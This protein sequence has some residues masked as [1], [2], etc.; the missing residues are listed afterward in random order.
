KGTGV[1]LTG[2][3]RYKG[4]NKV[5]IEAE[6]DKGDA[7]IAALTYQGGVPKGIR[8]IRFPEPKVAPEKEAGRPAIVLTEDKTIQKAHKVTD[9]FGLYQLAGGREA[10]SAT[11]MF[12]KT[13]KVDLGK[14]KKIAR[15]E[16]SD[17]R[18]VVWQVEQKGGDD[19][20]LTLLTAA[21]L[22]G[23]PAKLVGLVGKVPAGFVLF[24]PVSI[25][26][27]HFDATEL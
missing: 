14:V 2:T 5:T 8:A 21:T 6:V 10:L 19:S 22:D 26:A 11:L 17:T 25:L 7:G 12:K 16:E 27:V 24:P 9:L 20:T 3:T 1:T 4:I 23:K 18:D 15:A 13:L